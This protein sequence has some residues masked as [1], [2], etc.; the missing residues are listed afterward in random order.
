MDATVEEV[1]VMAKDG[2]DR[3]S[4]GEVTVAHECVG[5]WEV[6][7]DER[8]KAGECLRCSIFDEPQATT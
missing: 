6:A 4:L 1:D 7:G 3:A 8:E 2:G 5:G